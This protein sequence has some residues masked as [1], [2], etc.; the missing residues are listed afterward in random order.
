ML[1]GVVVAALACGCS[2]RKEAS[3][4]P[5]PRRVPVPPDDR[6]PAHEPEIPR[7]IDAPPGMS[8]TVRTLLDCKPLVSATELARACRAA[9]VTFPSVDEHIPTKIEAVMVGDHMTGYQSPSCDIFFESARGDGDLFV[10][11]PGFGQQP[12]FG[13]AADPDLPANTIVTAHGGAGYA[14]KLTIEKHWCDAAGI[15]QLVQLVQSRLPAE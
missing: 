11:G 4:P 15:R 10:S 7:P 8:E 2:E 1:R 9:N 14:F 6:H 5:P 3:T 13:P 12:D